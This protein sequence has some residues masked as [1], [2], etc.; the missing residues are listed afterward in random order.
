MVRAKKDLIYLTGF[1]ASGKSTIAPILANTLGYEFLDIDAEITKVT[2]QSVSEI[3]H[4][5]G[6]PY[7]RS[8][9][10]TILADASRRHGWVVSLGGGTVVDRENLSVVQATGILIYLKTDPEHIFRRVKYKTDRP[11][12]QSPDGSSLPDEELRTRI[13]SLLL[14]REPFYERADLTIRT[15]D[16]RV[17]ITVDEIVRSIKQNIV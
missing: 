2:G 16:K 1:M 10:R 5:Y 14:L 17:G 7:F 9:E 3:F 13:S 6:E 8:V 12:L 4:D 15:D 11:L